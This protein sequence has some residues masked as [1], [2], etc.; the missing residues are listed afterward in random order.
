[1]SINEVKVETFAQDPTQKLNTKQRIRQSIIP[2]LNKGRIPSEKSL[3]VLHLEATKGVEGAPPISVEERYLE[4][5]EEIL[6][7]QNVPVTGAPLFAEALR[8][9]EVP[10]LRV[11]VP[12]GL[13]R[14]RYRLLGEAIA[15]DNGR[16]VAS[17]S[18]WDFR[19]I[20]VTISNGEGMYVAPSLEVAFLM[21]NLSAK[22]DL[23]ARKANNPVSL[24]IALAYYYS[25]GKQ[26]IHP[27]ED[28]NTRAFDL[29]LEKEFLRIG[30]ELN[31][32][33]D[34]SVNIPMEE[35]FRI[36][37]A[38]FCNNFLRVNNLRLFQSIPSRFQAD[39]YQNQLV[40][41]LKRD[42]KVGLD[43]PFYK[44][45][46]LLTAGGLLKWTPNP[47][48]DQIE[49]LKEATIKEGNIVVEHISKPEEK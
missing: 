12:S 10:Y 11:K 31:I 40:H 1:M 29:F 39:T 21:S 48:E 16:E 45:M 47:H 36:Y 44:Y 14:G 43:D 33:Q 18:F 32:P 41:A 22:Y 49:S 28:G 34:E 23:L 26:L 19:S 4:I 6:R 3:K 30:V 20:K 13:G 9:E 38:N 15:L 17:I 7:R 37:V 25:M 42:I 2:Q 27:F 24:A 35:R 8:R 46:Y 5:A